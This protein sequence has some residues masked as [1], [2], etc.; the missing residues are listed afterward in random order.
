VR[1]SIATISRTLMMENG[2]RER[3]RRIE[4]EESALVIDD[5]HASLDQ[6]NKSRALFRGIWR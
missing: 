5:A 3:E 1:E 4:M 2:D 6:V